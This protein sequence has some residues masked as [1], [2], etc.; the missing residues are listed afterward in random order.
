MEG[1]NQTLM[2]NNPFYDFVEAEE[3]GFDFDSFK[4]EGFKVFVTSSLL[5][6]FIKFRKNYIIRDMLSL[7]FIAHKFNGSF[8]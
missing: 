7:R 6:D 4:N 2:I 8:R 1:I 3:F 5:K